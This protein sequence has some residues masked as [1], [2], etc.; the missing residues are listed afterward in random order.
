MTDREIRMWLFAVT[1]GRDAS[2]EWIDLA[3]AEWPKDDLGN[4]D[5]TRLPPRI[6]VET[7]RDG[8]AIWWDFDA[9]VKSI[10]RYFPYTGKDESP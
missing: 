1:A 10:R 4:P 9:T 3:I 7:R 8:G 5:I 6:Y 2:I